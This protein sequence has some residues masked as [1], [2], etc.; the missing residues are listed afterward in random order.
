[1]KVTKCAFATLAPMAV[2]TALFIAAPFHEALAQVAPPLG[3][4]QS[5]AV[6]GGASVVNTG[7]TVIVGR[8]CQPGHSDQRFSSRDRDRR[9]D[10]PD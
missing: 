8:G 2:L 4:T 3:T 7:S 9:N 6:L 5:F 1:M 10:T